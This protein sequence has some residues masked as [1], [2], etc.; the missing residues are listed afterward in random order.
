MSAVF[1]DVSGS[2][3]F[4]IITVAQPD[5]TRGSIRGLGSTM[6]H[7]GLEILVGVERQVGDRHLLIQLVAID[8]YARGPPGPAG[9]CVWRRLPGRSGPRG[10]TSR[11]TEPCP[12]SDQRRSPAA[13]P[14]R[15]N[16]ENS[17][18]KFQNIRGDSLVNLTRLLSRF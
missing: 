11:R 15:L 4:S 1:A 18:A 9:S 6:G 8:P 7:Y 5:E 17:R 16:D 2:A 3:G 13:A 14:C 12:G 10:R